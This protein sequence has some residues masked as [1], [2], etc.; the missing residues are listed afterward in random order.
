M[1]GTQLHNLLRHIADHC[2][3]LQTELENAPLHAPRYSQTDSHKNHSRSQPPTNITTLTYITDDVAPI[4]TGWAKNLAS[5]AHLT[6]LPLG[7][8]L[9]TWCAWLNRHRETLLTMDWADDCTTE[10]T[11]LENELRHHIH[12]TNPHQIKLPDYAT[13]QEIGNA[14][15]K[16]PDAIYKWCKRHGVTAYKI[17]GKNHFRTRELM[18]KTEAVK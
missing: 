13:A 18:P 17:G 7:Q 15:G 14:L 16:T 6:G 10:L 4:I 9:A 12:P 5:S 8:P 11:D 1:N 3:H 2:H